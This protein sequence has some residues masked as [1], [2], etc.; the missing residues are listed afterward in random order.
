MSCGE[1]ALLPFRGAHE[2]PRIVGADRAGADENRVA[3]GAEFI[4]FIEVG[5]GG[6]PQPLRGGVV[7][8]AVHRHGATEDDPG[9]F[10]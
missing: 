10:A 9:A 1:A 3:G 2:Q 7:D 8:I 6:E 5:F 4:D